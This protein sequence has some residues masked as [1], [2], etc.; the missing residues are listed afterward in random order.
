MTV[1]VSVGELG[2]VV[3]EDALSGVVQQGRTLATLAGVVDDLLDGHG[4]R[5]APSD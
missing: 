3:A 4:V 1:V 5:P 2:I